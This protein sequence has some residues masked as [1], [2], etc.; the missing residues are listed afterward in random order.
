MVDYWRDVPS[1]PDPPAH[2]YVV[3][4]ITRASRNKYEYDARRG[5]F[6]LDRVLYTFYPCDYGFIPGTLDDDGDP[7]DAVL[8]INEPTFTSCV[9]LARPVAVLRM[10]DEG[11]LDSKIIT[12]S[13]SDP[14]YRHIG[15]LADIPNSVREEL[16][17]FYNHYKEPEGKET[18]VGGWGEVEEARSLIEECRQRYA[19]DQ[20]LAFAEDE[21]E[22]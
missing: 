6:T 7:L 10:C 16:D 12:V 15:G 22:G 18:S 13:A 5:V 9:T 8:L 2:V 4:E 21:E 20:K 19:E 14:F 11:R 1:G 17:Y 3:T